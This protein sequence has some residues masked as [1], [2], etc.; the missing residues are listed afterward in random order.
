MLAFALIHVEFDGVTVGAMER[1][2]AIEHYLHE[3]FAGRNVVEIADRITEGGIVD[4][5]GLAGL[6]LID[7]DAED[8][9]RRRREANLHARLGTGVIG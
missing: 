3:I 5:R 8:H 4:D 7:I 9:L 1:F 6:Q 2:I